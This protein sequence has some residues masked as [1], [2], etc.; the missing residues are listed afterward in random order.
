M[1]KDEVRRKI[2][3][4][5][6]STTGQ[7][8]DIQLKTLKKAGCE[9]IFCEKI[10]G[11]KAQRA[12]LRRMIRCIKKEDIVIVTRIDRLAR[13]T[14]DLFSI[15]NDITH[16]GANF[17]SISEPWA[18]TNTSTGRL[19]LAVLAGL[20][21]VERDLIKTR[22]A[23]GRARAIAEGKRM[24]R[25]SRMTEQEKQEIIDRRQKGEPLKSL[26][27]AFGVSIATISRFTRNN[28]PGEAKKKEIFP[29]PPASAHEK[30]CMIL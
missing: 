6:V 24:G 12:Q 23:E 18:D 8:L 29:A 30:P 21:D 26:A 11:A 13:S 2:G 1:K 10:S 4:A 17:Y 19:M 15:V 3:Y 7:T 20:A 27:C 16:K 9:K 5:R 28:S 14:F 25:P 22:T